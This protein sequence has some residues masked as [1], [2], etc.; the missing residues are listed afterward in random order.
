MDV[1]ATKAT[2]NDIFLFVFQH[3]KNIMAFFF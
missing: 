1:P 3:L 2:Q